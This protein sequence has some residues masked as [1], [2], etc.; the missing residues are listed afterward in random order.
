[1]AIKTVYLFGVIVVVLVFGLFALD[2][3]SWMWDY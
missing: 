2:F 3:D 1:M